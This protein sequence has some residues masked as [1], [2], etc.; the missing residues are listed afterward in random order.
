[1]EHEADDQSGA[2]NDE[3]ARLL[4]L[5]ELESLLEELD[6]SAPLSSET[7]D[8]LTRHS[9]GNRDELVERIRAMHVELDIS[10]S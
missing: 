3:Y 9:I 2:G 10:H 6:E 1:M 4:L 5:D 8:R 7:A